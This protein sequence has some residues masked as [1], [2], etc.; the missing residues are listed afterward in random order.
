MVTLKIIAYLIQFQSNLT[1]KE[2]EL[3]P[4]PFRRVGL[5]S[6]NQMDQS[7]L[8]PILLQ[9]FL[10]LHCQPLTLV[11][12]RLYF[13]LVMGQNPHCTHPKPF[14]QRLASPPNLAHWS[15]SVNQ[16]HPTCQSLGPEENEWIV[17]LASG[18]GSRPG[19][20]ASSTGLLLP[21]AQMWKQISNPT[22]LL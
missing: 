13:K 19:W 20:R 7:F 8:H 6:W 12:L 4:F 2:Y 3:G 9:L 5:N 10:V 17:L 16:T 22:K 18:S 14:H 21:D 1:T 11:P 15:T